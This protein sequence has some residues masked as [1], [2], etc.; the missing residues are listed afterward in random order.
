MLTA[1]KSGNRY[2]YPE[3]QPIGQYDIY[4]INRDA[5]NIEAFADNEFYKK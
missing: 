1:L 3:L 4:F 5:T 2:E